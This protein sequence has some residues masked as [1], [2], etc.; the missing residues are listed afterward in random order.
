MRV[1]MNSPS[2][3]ILAI[4]AAVNSVTLAGCFL[5]DGKQAMTVAPQSMSHYIDPM[6]SLVLAFSSVVWVSAA[7]GQASEK[8]FALAS[9]MGAGVWAACT[10]A[11][12]QGGFPPLSVAQ[13]LGGSV[14]CL[15]M[16]Y[17]MGR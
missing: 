8:V 1:S 14:L 10:V 3:R 13:H 16:L 2:S 9:V 17:A 11:A 7:V 4:V 15:S 12:L 6:L 5:A